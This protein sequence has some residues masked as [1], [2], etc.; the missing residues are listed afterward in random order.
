[1]LVLFIVIR[2]IYYRYSMNERRVFSF[3][4]MGIM[5]FLVCILLKS[6]EIQLGIALGLFAIFAILRFR[7][8]NL[9]MRDMTYF[10]T[11]IGVSVIN[12]MATFY[13]PVRGMIVINSI[14][15]L[16]T[17]ILEVFFNKRAYDTATLIYDRLELLAPDKIQELLADISSRSSKKVEKVEI[18]KIDLIKRNAE[19]EIS[20]RSTGTG[21]QD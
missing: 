8:R 18:K 6:V 11:V 17:F 7:S 4:Q 10:F 13:N 5:I 14:I 15:I 2:L 16:S 21:N 9:S 12:A 3:F 20:F 19:L 1:M